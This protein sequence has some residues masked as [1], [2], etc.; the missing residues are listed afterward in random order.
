MLLPILAVVISVGTLTGCGGNYA[1]ERDYW[2][3]GKNH[4]AAIKDPATVA[5]KD[6]K[7]AVASL[8]D[9]VRRHPAWPK[10]VEVQLLVGELYARR[11]EAAR[12]REEFGRLVTLFP[13]QREFCARARFA[14]GFFYEQSGDIPH[15]IDEYREIVTRYLLS[16]TGVKMPLYIARLIRRS[17]S[18]EA[19][20]AYNDAVGQYQGIIERNPYSKIVPVLMHLAVVSEL[21]R[22]R[23]ECALANLEKFVAKFP[24]S[25]GAA[26]A[27]Y[28]TAVIYRDALQQPERMET[29]FKRILNEYP[30]HDIAPDVQLQLG[31]Y[32]A[33][34]GDDVRAAGEFKK[35]LEHYPSNFSLCARAG[36]ALAALYEKAGDW[37]GALQEYRKV[38]KNYPQTS[39]ALQTP[40]MVAAHYARERNATAAENAYAE[41][42]RGYG[43][44][45]AAH[46]GKDIVAQAEELMANAYIMQGRFPEAVGALAQL[47]KDYP[48]DPR[49]P[50]ALFR[51]ADIYMKEMNDTQKATDL[52]RTLMVEYPNHELAE[53]ARRYLEKEQG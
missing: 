29:I 35:V 36:A 40:L 16:P 3:A 4:G 25:Y 8:A 48:A 13:E 44:I 22:Q 30:A 43:D 1:A 6:F 28:E 11:G 41:A 5:E 46:P 49:A 21:E 39:L 32:Y 31:G 26:G 10:A 2:K 45:I 14:M 17:G 47:V 33:M 18:E 7:A 42:V 53:A 12:A 51:M 23:S 50:F 34:K 15:A 9:I 20:K 52:F 37:N 38:Q 24:K 19:D 27:L